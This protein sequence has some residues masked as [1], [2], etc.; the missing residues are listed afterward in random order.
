MPATASVVDETVP[1]IA[2]VC[3]FIRVNLDIPLTLASLGRKSGMSGAHLQRLFKRI[4]GVSPRQYADACRLDRL[5][6]HLKEGD[7]VTLAMIGAGYGSTSRLYE[8]STS[9]LG[10]TPQQY[11]NGAPAAQVRFATAT[12]DLGYV[13]LAAT[14]RGICAVSLGDT[15]AELAEFLSSEFPQAALQPDDAGLAVWLR[16][17]LRQL[18]GEQPHVDLPLDV[19]ATAFQRK[20]WEELRRIPY[21]ETR[22]Y[23][24]VAAALGQPKAIR[25][26][27]RA[28]ATNPVSIV[29]PCHRVVGSDGKLTGYRWG[30]NRKKMLL[31]RE[32]KPES[33]SQ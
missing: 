24:Q 12:C 31:E 32:A 5:K 9:Q 29:I 19:R 25:A 8:R 30:V 14:D 22:S 6:N 20:V 10:M 3:E 15:E 21:G 18:A 16:A 17:L 7:N 27:A 33:A 11:R 26:V 28:C 1:I 4:V 2:E 23:R 13:L